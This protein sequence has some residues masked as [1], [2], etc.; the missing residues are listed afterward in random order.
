MISNSNQPLV[1]RLRLRSPLTA[2]EQNALLCLPFEEAT[3]RGN[4]DLV[5]LGEQTEASYLVVSGVIGRFSQMRSGVRQIV[6]LHIAGEM[7]DLC[8]VVLPKT[9][10][11]FHA[12]APTTIL[13]I[14]HSDLITVADQYPNIA[15]AFW[16]DC[17]ADMAVMSEWSVSVARRPAE[18]KLAHLLCELRCRYK[19]AGLLAIDG[20]YP[21]TATQVQIAE[22]LGITAIH[23]N[24]MIRSL[25][26]RGL[27][28]LSKAG[29]VIHDYQS[30]ARLAEF[31]PAYLHLDEQPAAAS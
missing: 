16:R 22:V 6:A 23:L 15:Q 9:S 14:A 17:V 10:W 19:Q 5:A 30:L 18:A 21:F 11:A 2:E 24:R 28:T 8:S 12:F 31:D 25:R 27:A 1:D 20:F 4:R 29:V 13:R 7:A 3:V 26:E